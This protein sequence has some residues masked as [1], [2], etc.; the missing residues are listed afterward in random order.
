MTNFDDSE[1][2]QDER[3]ITQHE[4]SDGQQPNPAQAQALQLLMMLAQQQQQQQQQGGN[5]PN[6]AARFGASVPDDQMAGIAAMLMAQ[7]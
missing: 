3:N 4:M 2:G 1:F 5:D 7:E 6:L